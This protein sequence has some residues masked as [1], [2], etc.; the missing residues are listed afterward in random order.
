MG[1]INLEDADAA[2]T[3]LAEARW[4]LARVLWD[5]NRTRARAK[6]LASKALDAYTRAGA[7]FSDERA[8]VDEWLKRKGGR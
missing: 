2:P 5:G 1:N 8:G 6:E 4:L 7:S 3:D